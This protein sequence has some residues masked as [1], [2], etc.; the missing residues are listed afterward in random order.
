VTTAILPAKESIAAVCSAYGLVVQSEDLAR[1]AS[2]LG[3]D[4]AWPAV[5][6]EPIFDEPWQGRAFAMAFE[7]LDRSG[8]PWEA[9]R[10]HLVAA[11]ADEPDRPYYES[12]LN[13]VERLVLETGMVDEHAIGR[14]RRD[15]ASYRYHEEGVGDI[16]TVPFRP[17]L[18]DDVAA[19]HAELYRVW[20]SGS[21]GPW[22]LRAFDAADTTLLDVEAP[23][24]CQSGAVPTIP[25]RVTS[26]ASSS[27]DSDSVPGGR[28]GRTR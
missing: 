17:E 16:E 19:C 15:A 27:S 6:G 9:F 24:P 3:G 22:R 14:A 26:A 18:L 7:V 1:A 28:A 10:R 2:L 20:S 5:D 21:P 8:L 4:A 13:A 12:W 11:I 23:P 25:L